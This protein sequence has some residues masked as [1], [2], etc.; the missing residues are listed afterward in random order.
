M[1]KDYPVQFT[2]NFGRYC[3]DISAFWGFSH[4]GKA[5][6]AVIVALDRKTL[7]ERVDVAVREAYK[8]AKE[9][10]G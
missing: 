1:N 5:F 10:Y 4:G 2:I 6:G 3:G 8:Q 7:M 9:M